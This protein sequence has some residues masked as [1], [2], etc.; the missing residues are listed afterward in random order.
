MEKNTD[1]VHNHDRHSTELRIICNPTPFQCI[2]IV[3]MPKYEYIKN[4]RT[5]QPSRVQIGILESLI[6]IHVSM[7]QCKNIC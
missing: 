3:D 5:I 4:F 7:T 1:I 6:K 2:A